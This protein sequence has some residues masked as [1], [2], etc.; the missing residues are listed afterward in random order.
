MAPS[1]ATPPAAD[2][3]GAQLSNTKTTVE[4]A[5]RWWRWPSSR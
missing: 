5:P 2:R 3:S 4:F 1:S